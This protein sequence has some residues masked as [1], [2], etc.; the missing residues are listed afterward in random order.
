LEEGGFRK[1]IAVVGLGLIGGSYAMALRQLNAGRIFGIDIDE[2]VLDRA[3]GCGVIDEGASDAEK[4][5]C[6]S[7]MVIIALY[8][9]DTIEFIKNSAK[10]FKPGA[11]IT[12]TCGIKHPIIEA[13][14]E[15]LPENVE[16]VGGHPMAGNEFQG[17]DAASRELFIDT[18]YIITPHDKNSEKGILAV[19]KMAAAIGCKCVTKIG[20]EAH[21]RMISFTSQLPHIVA[22]SFANLIMD[23]KG[24]GSFTGRSFKDATRV[25][26]LN[27]ELWAQIFRMNNMN[28]IDRIEDMENILQKLKN[29]VKEQDESSLRILFDN[30]IKGKREIG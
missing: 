14:M 10:Y 4:M 27:K 5:L 9:R 26:A 15:S 2:S 25:A 29:A 17:F 22:I 3:A 21:D 16:F 20:T 28:I 6:K 19:E 18:N 12:D 30:A 7:D 11:I 8:P 24:M 1:N 13:A 23:E